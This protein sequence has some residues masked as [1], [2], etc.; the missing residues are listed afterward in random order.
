MNAIILI[1]AIENI[2]DN[3]I[4]AAQNRMGYLSETTVKNTVHTTGS[5]RF[6]RRWTTILVA[7]ILSLC[8]MGAGIAAVIYGENIQSWFSHYWEEI[9]GQSMSEGHIAVI[10]HLS[11]EIG[12]SQ[13]VGD[14]TI[15][16]DSATV[17]DDNFFLLLKV[18]GMDFS[19]KHSYDFQTAT[20]E[21]SP[22]PLVDGAFVGWGIDYIGVDGDGAALLLL[23]YEYLSD[24][25]FV[26]DARP[27]QVWLRLGN[28]ARD[29]HTD[30]EKVLLEG[31]W[32]YS[33]VI[34]R[35]QPIEVFAL[36][37]TEVMATDEE[38]K[39]VPV[40]ITNIE[41]TNTGLRFQYDYDEGTLFI[42]DQRIVVVLKNGNIME[43]NGG[44]GSP[45]ED[46]VGMSYTYQWLVPI[47]LDEVEAVKIGDTQI[48]VP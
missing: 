9:T 42:A 24:S 16:M 48:D 5:R 18:G 28:L 38:Q 12:V 2:D 14:V 30:K 31:E 43:N 29:A 19:N 13:T 22:D 17:G 6:T 47:N 20:M 26:Q 25:G 8:L 11:Q 39:E 23:N 40:M 33:F 36:P 7:A 37:D 27:L 1:N 10:E 21:T 3:Y 34:D 15:T 41:L 46:N 35:S 4:S 32:H 44:I 45:T